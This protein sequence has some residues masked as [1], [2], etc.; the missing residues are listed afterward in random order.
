VLYAETGTGKAFWVTSYPYA[1][2]VR[3]AWAGAW[4]C[5][6]FRN[7]G[8]GTAHEMIMDALKATR[9]HFGEP[10]PL[11]MVTFINR[12]KVKP[13]MRRGTQHW[14]YTYE[15]AGFKHVGETKGGLLAYQILPENM[16]QAE[17]ARPSSNA[18]ISF[19]EFERSVQLENI[20]K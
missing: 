18:Q 5:S 1:E 13:I 8:A 9:A 10:P 6:A 20:K 3:H 19:F 7:E 15:L 2:Y 17:A 4:I 16:P 11:G 12:Q 14:G